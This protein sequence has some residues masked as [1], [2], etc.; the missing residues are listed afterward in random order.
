M[1]AALAAAKTDYQ[2]MEHSSSPCLLLLTQGLLR[3]WAQ[4]LLLL[5]GW[6]FMSASRLHKTEP[7]TLMSPFGYS[8]ESSSTII[9]G[10]THLVSLFSTGNLYW[11]LRGS[12]ICFVKAAQVL[13][14]SFIPLAAHYLNLHRS[15]WF[16]FVLISNK[17]LVETGLG[18]WLPWVCVLTCSSVLP[19]ASVLHCVSLPQRLRAPSALSTCAQCFPTFTSCL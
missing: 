6:Q 19:S 4:Q 18:F 5:Q 7:Q 16:T 14:W 9:R 11:K 3:V 2:G 13:C 15:F 17:E 10:V 8:S 1:N 12:G